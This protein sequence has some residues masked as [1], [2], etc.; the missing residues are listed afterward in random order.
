MLVH[1]FYYFLF[2]LSICHYNWASLKHI[3]AVIT[4]TL[5]CNSR[6][7]M[8]LIPFVQVQ[9][10]KCGRIRISIFF[11]FGY[12][13]DHYQVKQ[14][15]KFV[16]PTLGFLSSGSIISFGRF[17]QRWINSGTENQP[18]PSYRYPRQT[19]EKHQNNS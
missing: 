3:Y 15:K 18:L 9:H 6:G 10:T 16:K 17:F 8:D 2:S 12:T 4:L 7:Y 5:F 19:Q 13:I 1:R 11:F 14:L